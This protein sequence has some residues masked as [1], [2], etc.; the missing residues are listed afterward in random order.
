M[1]DPPVNVYLDDP[2]ELFEGWQ[3]QK[4]SWASLNREVGGNAGFRPLT[5]KAFYVFGVQLAIFRCVSYLLEEDKLPST[6]YLPAY[7]LFASGIELLGRCLR[8]NSSTSGSNEDLKTGLRWLVSP[9]Y[10]SYKKIPYSHPIVRTINGSYSISHLAALRNY[11]THAQAAVIHDPPTIDF[12]IL[13]EMPSLIASGLESYWAELQRK[14]DPCNSLAKANVAAIRNR[15]IF[16]TL[17]A[18][19]RQR[20]GQYLAIGDVFGKLDWTY[21]PFPIK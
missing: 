9:D 15:P 20:N 2:T 16:D 13:Q 19:S 5:V 21:K 11:A 6:T 17:W 18:F 8:G 10:E 14:P 4:S 3:Q 12:L 1:S 7:A